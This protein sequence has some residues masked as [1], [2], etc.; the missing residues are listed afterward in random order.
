MQEEIIVNKE[1]EKKGSSFKKVVVLFFF[2]LLFFY[3]YIRFAEPNF[4]ITKEYAIVDNNLPY[5]FH[6]L[7]IVHFS[8]I[9]YGTS[10]NEKKLEN[11]VNRINELKP[12]IVLFT[13]DLFNNNIDTK[14]IN[15]NDLIAIL[16]KINASYKKYA[17][18]GDNDYMDKLSYIEI[19]ESANFM[20]L[21][22]KNDVFYY[23][24]NEPLQF[25]GTNSLLDKEYDVWQALTS[26]EDNTNAYKIWIS[27]E[28]TILDELTKQNIS[29]NLIFTGHT[30]N[31]L[32]K[33][34]FKGYLLNQEGIENY[35][36]N[37][38][39]INGTKMYI[40]SGLGTLKYNVRFFNP[41]SISF[42]RLYQY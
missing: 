40:S 5:S 4:L 12:D 1:K 36:D 21:N 24:G 30:L 28:P 13:G 25:I 38:Y 15:K 22:N 34:P 37:D 33:M 31:G 6:G 7:K 11:V 14:S 20:V 17:V 23:N 35:T 29:P 2:F 41:P 9:L 19:M 39:D 3:C 10:I 18:I 27:H 42:Y 8:D 26:I 32:I 16:S